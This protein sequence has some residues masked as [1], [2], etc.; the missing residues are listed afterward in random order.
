MKTKKQIE[1]E[2]EKTERLQRR[3][4]KLIKE[5]RRLFK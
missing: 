2:K 4:G 3:A 1:K 5:A